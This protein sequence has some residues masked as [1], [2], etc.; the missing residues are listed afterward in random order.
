MTK[1][2]K[3]DDLTIKMFEA[4]PCINCKTFTINFHRNSICCCSNECLPTYILKLMNDQSVVEMQRK[5]TT[6]EESNKNN[7]LMEEDND[8]IL[9]DAN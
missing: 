7:E 2:R 5:G 8:N 6:F 3:R 4:L 1:K 9:L